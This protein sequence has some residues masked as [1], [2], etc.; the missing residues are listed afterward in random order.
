MKRNTTRRKSMVM[1]INQDT[2]I[3]VVIKSII[4]HIGKIITDT[5]KIKM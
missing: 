4:I 1:A 5:M 3:M 2:E